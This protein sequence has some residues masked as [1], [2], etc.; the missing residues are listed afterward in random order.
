[1]RSGFG[2]QRLDSLPKLVTHCPGLGSWHLASLPPRNFSINYIHMLSRFPDKVLVS[3]IRFSE[4]QKVGEIIVSSVGF[5]SVVTKLFGYGAS[6]LSKE[7]VVR[8]KMKSSKRD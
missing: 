7:A 2:H 8:Q 3:G 6:E 4:T 1:M 5:P